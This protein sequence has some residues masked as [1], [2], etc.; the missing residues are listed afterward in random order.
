MARTKPSARKFTGGKREELPSFCTPFLS[1]LSLSFFHS[2]ISPWKVQ[3]STRSRRR[4]ATVGD[5]V[6]RQTSRGTTRTQRRPATNGHQIYT[7]KRSG[8]P[9]WACSRRETPSPPFSSGDGRAP[10]NQTL[11]EINRAPDQED[12]VPAPRAR[13]CAVISGM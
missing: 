2:Q 8:R 7:F 12:A 11:P 5:Q 10:R 3:W 4:P 1:S 9:T 13:D 6:H